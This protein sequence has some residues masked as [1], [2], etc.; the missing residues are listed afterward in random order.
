MSYMSQL[1]NEKIVLNFPV[2]IFIAKTDLKYTESTQ[3]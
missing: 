1:R 2:I 3:T